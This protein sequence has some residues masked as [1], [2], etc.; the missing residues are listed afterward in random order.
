MMRRIVVIL[1]TVIFSVGILLISVLRSA[2]INYAFSGGVLSNQEVKGDSTVSPIK[3]D[4]QLPHPGTILPDSPLWPIKALRD[5]LWLMVTT[6]PSKEA[7]IKLLVADKRLAMAQALFEKGKPELGFAVLTKAEKYL[8]EVVYLE[9]T[10]RESGLDTSSFLISLAK[11]SLKHRQVQ[12]EILNLAPEDAKP[13]IVS[14][15]RYATAAFDSARDG[16]L[17]KGLIVPNNPFNG[18]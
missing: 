9:K 7:E 17:S 6:N 1:S 8:E 2:S 12:E 4:Y 14:V 13:E 11:A 18:E 5:K 10:N 15:G 3:I 16:L